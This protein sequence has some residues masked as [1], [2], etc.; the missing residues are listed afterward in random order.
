MACRRLPEP[1]GADQAVL[2]KGTTTVG[3]DESEV[4]DGTVVV[5]KRLR[6]GQVR[7]FFADLKLCLVGVEACAI[8]EAVT[9]PSV[10]FVTIKSG[11]RQAVLML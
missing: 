10:R 4:A 3:G 1:S 8:C 2:G 6:R 5:R 11:S 9:R 7:S